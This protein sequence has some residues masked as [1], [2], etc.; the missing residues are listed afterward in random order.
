MWYIYR[1]LYAKRVNILQ[2][3]LII[4]TSISGWRVNWSGYARLGLVINR[5]RDNKLANARHHKG[6]GFYTNL[7][8]LS[9]GSN[10]FLKQMTS[11]EPSKAF[12]NV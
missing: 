11:F 12:H 1:V 4:G 5:L 9:N 2:P 3:A 6:V 7:H 10:R 8:C